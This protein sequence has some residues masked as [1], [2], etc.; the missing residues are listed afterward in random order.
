VRKRHAAHH[1][2][3]HENHEA[4]VIPYAD[5]LTLLMGLFVVLWAISSADMAKLEALQTSFAGS[6]GMA[7]TGESAASGGGEG[8]LDGTNGVLDGGAIAP[9]TVGGVEVS[10]ERIEDA[11][12]ALEREEEAAEARAIEDEQLAA[13]EQAITEHAAATGVAHAVGFRRE[14]RGLVVSIVSDQVLFEPGS[15]ELRPEGRIVL[16]GLAEALVALPNPIAIEG[17]TDDVPISTARF[18]SNWELSTARATSV[19]QHLLSAYAFPPHRLT[20]SGYG[21]QHPVADNGDPAGRSR[22]RRV[23]IAVLSL[24]TPVTTGASR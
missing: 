21:E 16:D 12:G 6:L 22:N 23:D 15:A 14:D 10:Q 13:V 4:W 20:A 24:T 18:P 2:E 9:V 19:L 8:A 3:E 17:H 5:M 11:V 1:E 7:T